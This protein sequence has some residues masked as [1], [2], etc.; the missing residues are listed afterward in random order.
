M[1]N[2][3]DFEAR[4]SLEIVEFTGESTVVERLVELGLCKGRSI[5]LEHKAPFSGPLIVKCGDS[6]LALREEEARCLIVQRK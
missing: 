5:V 4:T 1:M 2:I 3:S 6:I